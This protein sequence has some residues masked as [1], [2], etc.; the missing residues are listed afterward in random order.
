MYIHQ[1]EEDILDKI[2]LEERHEKIFL[3]RISL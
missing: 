3:V 1:N 2:N